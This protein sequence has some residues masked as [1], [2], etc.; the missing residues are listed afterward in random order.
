MLASV[1]RS[2]VNLNEK[3][4]FMKQDHNY[5]IITYQP[6]EHNEHIKKYPKLSLEEKNQ[7][8]RLKYLKN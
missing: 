2:Y 4:I 7:Y 5:N 1:D 3:D 8:F 6:K